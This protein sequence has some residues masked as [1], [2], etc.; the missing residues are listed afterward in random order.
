MRFA[1]GVTQ[2]TLVGKQLVR[3]VA[4]MAVL[5]ALRVSGGEPIA[6]G[7]A[8]KLGWQ[9]LFP[10]EHVGKVDEPP[11]DGEDDPEAGKPAWLDGL[12]VEKQHEERAETASEGAASAQGTPTTLEEVEALSEADARAMAAD[13]GSTDKRWSAQKVRRFIADELGL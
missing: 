1:L 6:L 5:G 10:E 2:D 13:L 3:L 11:S 4:T 8:S 9:D 12:K 7:D